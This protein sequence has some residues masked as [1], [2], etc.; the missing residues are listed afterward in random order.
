[1]P[2]HAE[3]VNVAA[4]LVAGRVLH[5]VA[6]HDDTGTRAIIVT[7]YEPDPNLWDATL[8]KRMAP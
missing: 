2:P 8:R 5:V 7:V 6:A 4:W 1:M 3:P